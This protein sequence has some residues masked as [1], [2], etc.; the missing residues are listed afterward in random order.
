MTLAVK[1]LEFINA[2]IRL[3]TKLKNHFHVMN[4]NNDDYN[5][6]LRE[7]YGFLRLVYPVPNIR[8]RF[9]LQRASRTCQIKLI[10]KISHNIIHLP[11][12]F[13]PIYNYSAIIPM[14][15]SKFYPCRQVF[16]LGFE[17]KWERIVDSLPL[18]SFSS[19]QFSWMWTILLV[20]METSNMSLMYASELLPYYY[21]RWFVKLF[22]TVA[23]WWV[24]R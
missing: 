8:F 2:I 17:T 5:V 10:T 22:T 1:A 20:L 11:N 9:N 13:C 3:L 24:I 18:I 19:E 16:G 6:F 23:R 21:I 15:Y 4:G 7:I 14:V 12:M